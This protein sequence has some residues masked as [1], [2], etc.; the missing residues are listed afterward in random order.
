MVGAPPISLPAEVSDEGIGDNAIVDADLDEAD[1]RSAK[2][3]TGDH[4]MWPQRLAAELGQAKPPT[5]RVPVPTTAKA[6]L[7]LSQSPFSTLSPLG[8]LTNRDAQRA[9]VR[10]ELAHIVGRSTHEPLAA[11]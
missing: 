2:G 5:E 9:T 3:F 1:R 4:L 6:G 8:E 11:L 10:R 7:S